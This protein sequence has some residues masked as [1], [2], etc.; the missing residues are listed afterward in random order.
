[1]ARGGSITGKDAQPRDISRVYP[2]EKSAGAFPVD[3]GFCLLRFADATS[4]SSKLPEA[5][6]RPPKRR[7][8]PSS[9]LQAMQL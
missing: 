2:L 1:M 5:A 9:G 4:Q 6:L 8:D 3:L 7:N